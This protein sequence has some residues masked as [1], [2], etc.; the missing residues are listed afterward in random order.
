MLEGRPNRLAVRQGDFV[1]FPVALHERTAG[2]LDHHRLA[3]PRQDMEVGVDLVHSHGAVKD[4]IVEFLFASQTPIS[5]KD[6]H[7][8]GHAL[9]DGLLVRVGLVESNGLQ[10]P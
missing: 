5:S 1:E 4:G 3:V 10:L 7:L 6:D 2:W 9:M 8:L